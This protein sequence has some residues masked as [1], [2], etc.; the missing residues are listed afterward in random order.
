M[1]VVTNNYGYDAIY[2]LISA[3][4]GATTASYDY[5]NRL[6][7][8]GN[9]GTTANYKYDAFGRRIQ[10]AVTQDAQLITHNYIYDGDQIVAEYN[11]TGALQAK[12]IY[13]PGIDEPIKMEKGGISYYYLFDGL[14]TVSEITDN[15][16]SV[17]EKYEY[18]AYGKTTIKDASNN[19]LSQS[20]IGN[21]FGFTGRELDSDTGLYYYRA[22][23]YSPELGRFLQTDPLG[24][25]DENPYTYCSNDPVNYIDPYGYQGSGIIFTIW[26]QGL[27]QILRPPVL[28]PGLIGTDIGPTPG[29]NAPVN[30]KRISEG[31]EKALTGEKGLSERVTSSVEKAEKKEEG[32]DKDKEKKK[33][34][35]PDIREEK[36]PT[37]PHY[38]KKTKKDEPVHWHY[39]NYDWDPKEG[40]WRPGKWR[41]GGPGKAPSS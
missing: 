9:A 4:E 28:D 8:A 16:G 2:Q 6:I 36:P 35:K 38:D 29:E 14:G 23:Y 32:K 15:T 40:R 34:P 41:Y 37:P 21:R 7:S 12:Y 19:I 22:R 18:D 30:P 27:G 1:D 24:I 3:H 31:I 39:R 10:K 11:T 25:D 33:K 26:N 20:A 13:G 5:E 17:I